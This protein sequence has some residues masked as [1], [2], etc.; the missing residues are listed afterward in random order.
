MFEIVGIAA[1]AILVMAYVLTLA[2]R[3]EGLACETHAH[4]VPRRQITVTAR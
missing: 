2:R 3:Y 4:S 1:I